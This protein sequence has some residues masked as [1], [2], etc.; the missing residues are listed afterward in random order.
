MRTK[1]IPTITGDLCSSLKDG[2]NLALLLLYYAPESFSWHGEDTS[3][4]YS[5]VIKNHYN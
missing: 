2:R 1:G 3:S 4:Q 5:S